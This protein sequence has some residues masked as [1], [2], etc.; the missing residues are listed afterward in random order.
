M[1]PCLLAARTYLTRQEIGQAFKSSKEVLFR[2]GPKREMH[3]L[4]GVTLLTHKHLNVK[5][6]KDCLP[7][8]NRHHIASLQSIQKSVS[9]SLRT[10]RACQFLSKLLYH[11]SFFCLL[12][13]LRRELPKRIRFCFALTTTLTKFATPMILLV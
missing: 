5:N 3:C 2:A 11:Y 10:T 8:S 4:R 6:S 7:I 12:T 1:T 13:E 9:K